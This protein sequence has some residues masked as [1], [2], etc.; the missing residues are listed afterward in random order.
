MFHILIKIAKCR[1]FIFAPKRFLFD[2]NNPIGYLTAVTLEYILIGYTYFIVACTLALGM[3]L[4]SFAV[5]ITKEIQRILHA[6]NKKVQ[7]N[8][9]QTKKLMD[10]F[11]E[12][13]F[14]HATI[15]E[16]SIF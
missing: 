8:E 16:L 4:S 11:S 7:S 9:D 3:G 10:L 6:I 15:K 13:I 12:Y 1:F 14:T 5:S 2:T